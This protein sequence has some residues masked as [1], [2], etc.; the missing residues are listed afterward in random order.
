M[1]LRGGGIELI[2][3]LT[4]STY[5]PLALNALWALKNLTF[6]ADDALKSTVMSVLGWTDLRR[7][8]GKID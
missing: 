7:W 6:R 2:C 4:R 1:L 8:A 3:D 5:E